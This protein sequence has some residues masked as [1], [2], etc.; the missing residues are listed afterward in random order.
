VLFVGAGISMGQGGL[1]GSGQLAKELAQRCDY[2]GDNLLLPRV[3]QYY[4]D[5]VDKANLLQ[6]VC[7]RIRSSHGSLARCSSRLDRAPGYADGGWHDF[8]C[9]VG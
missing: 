5:I 1:P 3:A 8:G 9:R 2:P 6:Y 7:Q 4:A